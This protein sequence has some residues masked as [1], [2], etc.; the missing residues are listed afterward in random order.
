LGV[1]SKDKVMQIEMADSIEAS[2]PMGFN[3]KRNI[4][5]QISRLG[6][7]NNSVGKTDSQ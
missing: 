2:T 1:D 3:F 6:G 5:V 7:I 4:P